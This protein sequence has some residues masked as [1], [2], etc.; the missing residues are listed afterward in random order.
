ME[1]YSTF[2]FKILKNEERQGWYFEIYS[3]DGKTLLLVGDECFR[4]EGI[5]RYAAI[6]QIHLMEVSPQDEHS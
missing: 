2:S 5:A 6:G 3:F 1:T 4:Q